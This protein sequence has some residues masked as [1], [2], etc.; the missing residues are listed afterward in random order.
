MTTRFCLTGC[1]SGLAVVVATTPALAVNEAPPESRA[2]SLHIWYR[3]TEGCPDGQQFL[4]WLGSFG[5]DASLAK[6]GDR[7]DFVV[8]LSSSPDS[9]SGRLERQ[10]EEG[11][12]AIRE[13]RASGCQEVAEGLA[14]SLELALDP[15]PDEPDAAPSIEPETNRPEWNVGVGAQGT[16]ETGV[17][18]ARLWG[19]SAFG[20]LS[21]PE[22]PL[23]ARLSARGARA[24]HE[25]ESF[26]SSQGDSLEVDAWVWAGRAEAC[27][28]LWSGSVGAL[29][30]CAGAELGLIHAQS[31]GAAGRDDTGTWAAGVLHA[32]GVLRLG[33]NIALESQVGGLF[34]FV[35]YDFRSERGRPVSSSEFAG[36]QVAVGVSWWLGS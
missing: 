29:G 22:W 3:S 12:V 27:V 35:R 8:T 2:G 15:S 19:V 17:A 33:R 24:S 20:Q 5:R 6:V 21:A 28:T 16:L 23:A 30:P 11:T 34:P 25:S 32:R 1:A 4:A 7:I 13:L 26:S 10:S 9:S 14:L 18:S 36:L 31:S